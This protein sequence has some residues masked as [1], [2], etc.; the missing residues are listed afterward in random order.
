MHVFE[1]PFE[2]Q[3]R[4]AGVDEAKIACYR[5]QAAARAEANLAGLLEESG[6]ASGRLRTVVVHGDV[7]QRI[8]EYEQELDCDL[9]AV[10]KHGAGVFE[11]LLLGS[12]TKHLLAESQSDVLV[13]T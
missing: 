9:I 1:V 4:Y 12:T 6:I 10:G 3:L 11:E 13:V 7:S 8:L 5:T 2:G